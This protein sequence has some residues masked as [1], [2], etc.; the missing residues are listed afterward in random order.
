[1]ATDISILCTRPVKQT[2][3]NEA[4]ALGIY[5][6]VV[7]FIDTEPVQ[8]IDVQQ[9]VEQIALQYAT[10]V[11][12]SMNAVESVITMLNQQVPEWNIYCMGNTT[13]QIIKDYFGEN[14]IAGTGNSAADLA[15][16]IIELGETGE[17]VFFCGDQRRDELPQQLL[18]AGIE[19]NEVVVYKTIP[20]HKKVE[21]TYLAILF[22]SP[23]AV[24]SYF[25][26]NK[27]AADTVLFAIGQTTA[28]AIQQY[29]NNKTITANKPGKDELVRKAIHYLNE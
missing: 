3:V 25:K 4:A 6:Q 26:L 13:A 2:L 8:D 29:S 7:P 18:E 22:F 20:L 21:G 27:P 28:T 17:V 5:L 24:D 16:A 15:D 19:V 1:M 9:E 23:S 14:A 10:V 12:T 11:F